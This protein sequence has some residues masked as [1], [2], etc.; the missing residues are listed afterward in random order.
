MNDLSISEEF[1]NENPLIFNIGRQ[2]VTKVIGQQR[3]LID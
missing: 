3:Y 2:L 1:E